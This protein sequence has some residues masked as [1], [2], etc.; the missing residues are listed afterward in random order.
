MTTGLVIRRFMEG[1]YL[2]DGKPPA[3]QEN[4][5]ELWVGNTVKWFNT[6]EE[7]DAMRKWIDAAYGK[8]E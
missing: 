8:G 6:W 7:A 5:R 3:G 4:D 1:Y 2:C